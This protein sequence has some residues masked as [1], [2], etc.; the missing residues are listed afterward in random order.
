MTN[1]TR[2]YNLLNWVYHFL[3]QQYCVNLNR[4][5]LDRSSQPTVNRVSV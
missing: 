5:I 1:K 2:N 4:D 3:N